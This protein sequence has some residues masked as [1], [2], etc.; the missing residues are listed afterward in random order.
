MRRKL[1]QEH[2]PEEPIM[3]AKGFYEKE[4]WGG[5]TKGGREKILAR[6]VGCP[7]ERSEEGRRG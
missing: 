4:G 6:T 7:A 1:E 5:G 3:G 2:T